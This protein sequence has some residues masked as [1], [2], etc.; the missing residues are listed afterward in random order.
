VLIDHTLFLGKELSCSM[1][2]KPRI[3]RD[4][5]TVAQQEYQGS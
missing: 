3:H 1:H 4:D 5:F 2:R